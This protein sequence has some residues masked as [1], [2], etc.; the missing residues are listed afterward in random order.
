MSDSELIAAPSGQHWLTLLFF[1]SSFL[2]FSWIFSSMPENKQML[3][4]SAT[5]PESLAQQLTR[6]MR[7]PTFVRL[8]PAD[9]SLKGT[10]DCWATVV[11]QRATGG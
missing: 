3:A 10:V 9:M 1:S 8:N 4:L 5:Y 2:F 7:E 6:Y 11:L